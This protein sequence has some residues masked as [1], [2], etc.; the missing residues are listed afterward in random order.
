MNVLIGNTV[1]N[2][3]YCYDLW[4]TVPE[5]DSMIMGEYRDYY[6][7]IEVKNCL[8]CSTPLTENN[9]QLDHLIPWSRFPINRIWNLYPVCQRCNGEKSNLLIVFNE[10]IQERLGN[11][12]S[13]LGFYLKLNIFKN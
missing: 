4:K 10:E 13:L 3:Y 12:L 5:R 9:Y 1:P 6:T 7:K 8:Y 2:I 11:I